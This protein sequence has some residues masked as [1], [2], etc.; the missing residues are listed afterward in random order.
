M[1]EQLIKYYVAAEKSAVVALRVRR[2]GFCDRAPH[3]VS[4][5]FGWTTSNTYGARE[6]LMLPVG[7]GGVLYRPQFFHPIVFDKH[8]RELTGTGDDL[9]FR[10][11]TMAK[12][13]PIVSAC[14]EIDPKGMKIRKCP[15]F[16]IVRFAPFH[17]DAPMPL[18]NSSGSEHE[19]HGGKKRN[20]RSS[21]E[22]TKNTRSS[23]GGG[24]LSAAIPVNKN[25]EVVVGGRIDDHKDIE[26]KEVEEDEVEAEVEEDFE[27]I[28]YDR[29]H[30]ESSRR[31]LRILEDL[32]GGARHAS[33]TMNQQGQGGAGGGQGG[34]G[35]GGGGRASS[36]LRVLTNAT[37][38]QPVILKPPPLDLYSMN[39][40]GRNERQWHA[41]VKYLSEKRI[42]D[43]NKIVN[44]YLLGE[45]GAECNDRSTRNVTCAL[46]H[47]RH[48]CSA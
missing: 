23:S 19:V 12:N 36:L 1:L 20:L 42:L 21:V 43:F 5:Y 16:A 35:G 45:R 26:K 15:D 32:L 28:E 29:Y 14:T 8:L 31:Q 25:N 38:G 34:A 41:A 3:N 37:S 48:R 2:I 18:A 46:H 7:T 17:M 22:L 9:M 6:M 39:M 4:A 11:S 33:G 24:V 10:L 44:H 30:P 40:I 13:I 27:D 47:S